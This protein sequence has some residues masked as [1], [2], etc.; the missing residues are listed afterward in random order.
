MI[1]EIYTIAFMI[2]ISIT[3]EAYIVFFS[4]LSHTIF[5]QYV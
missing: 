5:F 1:V 2:E 4:N 3:L